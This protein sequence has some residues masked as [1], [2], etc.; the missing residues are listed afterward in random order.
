[1]NKSVGRALNTW[2]DFWQTR[3]QNRAAVQKALVQWHGH[4][5]RRCFV[6]CVV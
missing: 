6:R 2:V 3:V 5:T 4:A 1:M